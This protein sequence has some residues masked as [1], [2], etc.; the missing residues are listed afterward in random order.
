MLVV[1][2]TSKLLYQSLPASPRHRFTRLCNGGQQTG[3]MFF[4][5]EQGNEPKKN[6]LVIHPTQQDYYIG[7]GKKLKTLIDWNFSSM[8]I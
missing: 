2:L 7:I 5:T 3:S 4:L 1:T 6:I 8:M